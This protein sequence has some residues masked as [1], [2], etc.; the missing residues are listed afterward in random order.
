MLEEAVQ[1]V[2]LGDPAIKVGGLHHSRNPDRVL[3]NVFVAPPAISP[4]GLGIFN[5][6]GNSGGGR[7]RGCASTV[8]LKGRGRKTREGV[9]V[10]SSKRNKKTE[11]KKKNEKKKKTSAPEDIPVTLLWREALGRRF[12]PLFYIIILFLRHIKER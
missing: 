1:V 5:L 2:P 12:R 10:G 3:V 9:P 4:C 7:R 8:H 6:E 11:R